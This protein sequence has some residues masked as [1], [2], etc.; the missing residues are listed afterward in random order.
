MERERLHVIGKHARM[1]NKS[2]GFGGDR[3]MLQIEARMSVRIYTFNGS[4]AL[5]PHIG[6]GIADSKRERRGSNPQPP[7]RQ[8]GGL[9]RFGA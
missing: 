4:T 9:T 3:S 6:Q 2:R 5:A 1:D 7:D 8:S